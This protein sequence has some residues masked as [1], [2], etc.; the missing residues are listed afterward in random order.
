MMRTGTAEKRPPVDDQRASAHRPEIGCA[1]AAGRSAAQEDGVK[2]PSIGTVDIDQRFLLF[3]RKTAVDF[4]RP[5]VCG[6]M[7][8][9]DVNHGRCRKNG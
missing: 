1:E 5:A 6:P 8:P 7:K 4:F 2:C 9:V 3:V